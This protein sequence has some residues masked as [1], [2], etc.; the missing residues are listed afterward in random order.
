MKTDTVTAYLDTEGNPH[1][2][3]QGALEVSVRKV[4]SKYRHKWPYYMDRAVSMS[5]I[6]ED[7]P[8]LIKELQGLL[9][10]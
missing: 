7:L 9:D 8:N 2:T 10:E 5:K 6:A 4:F 1:L 3:K